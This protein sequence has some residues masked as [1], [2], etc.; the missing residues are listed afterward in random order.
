[1]TKRVDPKWQE[2]QEE[3]LVNWANA[4]LKGSINTR[5]NVLQINNLSE[6]IRDGAILLELLD[7]VS[8]NLGSGRL[9]RRRYREPKLEV[10]M[11]ENIAE[12]FKF[13]DQ[14]D[15]KTVNIG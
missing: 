2:V 15:I 5:S 10:Q 1:M 11:R 8:G 4:T 9:V 6:D 14:E 7:N 12:C 3:T 13:M